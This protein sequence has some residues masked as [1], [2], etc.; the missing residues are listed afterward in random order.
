MGIPP[1][2][3]DNYIAQLIGYLVPPVTGEYRFLV[4]AD[5]QAIVYLSTDADPA[6]K[7]AIAV[8]PQW[9]PFREYL[10][11]TRRRISDGA[12]DFIRQYFPDLDPDLAANDSVNTVGLTI[13]SPGGVIISRRS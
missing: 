1:N 5:D 3:S 4:A 12:S 2:V 6:N 13:W 9:N 8:E 10:G 11:A 7:F